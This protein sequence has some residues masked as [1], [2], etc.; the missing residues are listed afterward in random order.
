[1]LH[2]YLRHFEALRIGRLCGALDILGIFSTFQVV[3]FE[4]VECTPYMQR[5][6]GNTKDKLHGKADQF[7]KSETI[8]NNYN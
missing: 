3:Y 8:K 5:Y 2:C 6:L 1:M 7:L 4:N